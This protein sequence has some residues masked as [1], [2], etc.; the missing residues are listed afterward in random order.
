VSTDALSAEAIWNQIAGS[1][2]MAH[3]LGVRFHSEDA[4]GVSFA[5]DWSPHVSQP[6][7][8]FS[9]AALFGLADFASTIAAMRVRKGGFMLA[10][11]ASIHLLS[12]A[13]DGRVIA[14]AHVVRSGRRTSVVTADIDHESRGLL[15]QTT[16]TFMPEIVPDSARGS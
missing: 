15:A 16:I 5:L 7:G 3:T 13:R 11:D 4:G 2:D 9:A 10:I 6:G 14:R 8:F 12:N 1:P